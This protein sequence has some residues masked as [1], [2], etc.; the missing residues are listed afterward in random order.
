MPL[1]YTTHTHTHT[2]THTYEPLLTALNVIVADSLANALM[3]VSVLTFCIEASNHGIQAEVHVLLK[4]KMH[5]P[6]AA[7]IKLN[8]LSK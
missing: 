6:Q 4:K 2:H 5:L 3:I 8:K 1:T 7:A